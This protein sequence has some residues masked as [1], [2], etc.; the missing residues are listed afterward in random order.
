[1]RPLPTALLP[2]LAG[3]TLCLS[4]AAAAPVSAVTTAKHD[5]RLAFTV[6]G[7]VAKVHV[8]PGDTVK[9]GATLI[10]LEDEAGRASVELYALKANSTVSVDAADAEHKLAAVEEGRVREAFEKS[11]AGNF[12]VERAELQTRLAALRRAQ[13]VEAAE[14][15]KLQLAAARI[16]HDAY[17]LE[18][19]IDGTIEEVI[20]SEGE[21]VETLKPVLRLVA[22]DPLVIDAYVPTLDSLTLKPGAPAW[23][24]ARTAD[25][26]ESAPL[27][28]T[29]VYVAQ[30]ADARSD[31]R[32]VRVELPNPDK[33]PAGTHVTVDFTAPR[34]AASTN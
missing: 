22:A 8:K 18:A 25:S 9:A 6:P 32:L 21:T 4:T 16:A 12:E 13:A 27:Q 29:I 14:Q 33:H 28:G 34:A 15:A 1:M 30:V 5:L 23:V 10:E 3:L 17:S 19:R 26:A 20:V 24:R 11:A 31:T 7:R 2:L